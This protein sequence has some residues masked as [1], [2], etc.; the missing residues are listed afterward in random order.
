M[1]VRN[2][3]ESTLERSTIAREHM[4]LLLHQLIKTK[5]L[6]QEQ[7]CKGLQEILEVAED[8]AIDIPHIWLY[9]AELITPMFHKGGIPMG[10]LLRVTDFKAVD[11]SGQSRSSFGPHPYF[12][13]QRNGESVVLGHH[14][15]NL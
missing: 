1:F 9:L 13:L 12:T 15:V 11:P 4:D 8:M 5:I 3:L 10:N 6:P 2:G 14:G 7:Y